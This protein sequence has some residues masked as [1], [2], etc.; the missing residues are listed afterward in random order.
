MHVQWKYSNMRKKITSSTVGIETLNNCQI[1]FF[2]CVFN[3]VNAF[4]HINYSCW[5]KRKIYPLKF[6]RKNIRNNSIPRSHGE[7]HRYFS[8]NNSARVIHLWHFLQNECSNLNCQ[9]FVSVLFYLFI[10]FMRKKEKKLAVFLNSV[11]CSRLK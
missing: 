1:I 10:I 2:D 4:K 7:K 3:L 11:V 9:C 8:S 5:M 6:T